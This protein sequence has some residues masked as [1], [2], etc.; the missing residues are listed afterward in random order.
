MISWLLRIFLVTTV[1]MAPLDG[2]FAVAGKL[3]EIQQI[4]K[5]VLGYRKDA[6]PFSFEDESGNP[7]GYSIDLCRNVIVNYIQKEVLQMPELSIEWV[8]VSV[9]DRI[10]KVFSGAVSMECG[11]TTITYDR[12]QWV[13]FSHIIYVSGAKL[14]VKVDS[15]VRGVEDLNGRKIAV[16]ADTTTEFVIDKILRDK[17]INADLIRVREHE[18]GLNSLINGDI[19]AYAADHALLYGLLYRLRSQISKEYRLV[20]RFLSYEPYGIAL[21]RDDSAFRRAVNLA[22]SQHFRSGAIELTYSRW[23]DPLDLPPDDIFIAAVVL[24]SIPE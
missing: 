21:P 22:L 1:C 11:A 4:R 2:G 7:A 3:D 24:Q 9:K 13:D 10:E 15:S 6:F 16:L 18:D 5:I 20:G 19:D 14:L 12:Q 8:Q 17:N 23:F